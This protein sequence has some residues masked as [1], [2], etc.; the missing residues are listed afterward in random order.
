MLFDWFGAAE[1]SW[2]ELYL[3]GGE[4]GACVDACIGQGEGEGRE[5][6]ELHGMNWLGDD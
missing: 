5:L 4:C 6:S 3:G 1:L 2:V